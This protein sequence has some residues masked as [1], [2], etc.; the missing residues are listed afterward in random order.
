[1]T[2]DISTPPPDESAI[3]TILRRVIDP[4]VGMNIVDLG[5][6]YRVETGPARVLVEM[7]LPSPACPL[8]ELISD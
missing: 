5:L 2:A 1:M 3:R 7:T 8:G 4:E 6:V